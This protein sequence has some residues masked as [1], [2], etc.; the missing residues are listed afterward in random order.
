M[1]SRV[2]PLLR[3]RKNMTAIPGEHQGES[4]VS[5]GGRTIDG[6][7]DFIDSI[8]R[9]YAVRGSSAID[10]GAGRGAFSLR[11]RE[12]GFKVV[13]V[14]ADRGMFRAG[15]P[16]VQL[17]LNKPDLS[18]LVDRPFDLVAAVALIEHLE[19]PVGLLRTIRSLLKPE[20]IAVVTTPNMDNLPSRIRLLLTGKLHMMDERVPDHILPVFYDLFTRRYLPLAG[21]RLLEHHLYPP[22]G[23][24]VS[25]SHYAW[26]FRMLARLFP[27]DNLLGDVHVFVLC[28][29][30]VSG[31]R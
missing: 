5:R 15:L 20:G 25:R 23:Y 29:T 1:E 28:A 7:H 24:I 10:L 6:L 21:L 11:L 8:L 3:K 4:P 26:L 16:F 27:A 2:E 30:G 22:K 31:I 17:D 18:L 19:N 12:M 14:D 9:P 13:A